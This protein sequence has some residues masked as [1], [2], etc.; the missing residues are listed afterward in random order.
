MT[1]RRIKTTW[2]CAHCPQRVEI[3][4]RVPEPPIHRCKTRGD[5]VHALQPQR[6]EDQ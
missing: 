3:F 2:V 5:K 4:I 1:P 6:E